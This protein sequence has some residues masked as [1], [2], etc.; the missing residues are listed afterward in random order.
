MVGVIDGFRWYILGGDSPILYM[1][2]TIKKRYS[3]QSY[4]TI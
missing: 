3:L 2:T 1:W 4:L